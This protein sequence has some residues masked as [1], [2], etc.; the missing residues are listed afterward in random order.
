M[1]LWFNIY[2]CRVE[3]QPESNK[4][5]KSL[6]EKQEKARDTISEKEE[7]AKFVHEL[8]LDDLPQIYNDE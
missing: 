3:S 5:M 8:L 7:I 6:L 1:I 2:R 4:K